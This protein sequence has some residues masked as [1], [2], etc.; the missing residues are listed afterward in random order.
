MAG[1]GR[2]A[3]TEGTSSLGSGPHVQVRPTVK[4]NGTESTNPLPANCQF[5]AVSSPACGGLE[6]S[7]RFFYPFLPRPYLQSQES[8]RHCPWGPSP[9]GPTCHRSALRR[10]S[11]FSLHSCHLVVGC[12]VAE[13]I[14]GRGHEFCSFPNLLS[15]VYRNKCKLNE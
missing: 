2:M 10:T 11:L 12:A 5:A 3:T 1:T 15:Y 8:H 4:S 6:S 7:P 13:A 14:E 9:G